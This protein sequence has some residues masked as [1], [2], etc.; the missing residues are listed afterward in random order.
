MSEVRI[1]N[2]EDSVFSGDCG[3]PRVMVAFDTI[4]YPMSKRRREKNEGIKDH[5]MDLRPTKTLKI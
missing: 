3:A 4:D 5:T 1:E 2:L